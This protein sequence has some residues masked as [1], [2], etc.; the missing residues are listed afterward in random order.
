MPLDGNTIYRDMYFFRSGILK[1]GECLHTCAEK[2]PF[3]ARKAR[4]LQKEGGETFNYHNQKISIARIWKR[5]FMDYYKCFSPSFFALAFNPLSSLQVMRHIA[6]I[7]DK[8]VRFEALLEKT[9][10]K[11]AFCESEVGFDASIFTIVAKKHNV[12]TATMLHG[13]GGYCFP[14]YARSN[15]VVNYFLVPGNHYNKYLKPYCP[16]VDTFFP[17]GNHEVEEIK[18]NP[19]GLKTQKIP[20]ACPRVL[21][22][23]F[24]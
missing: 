24:I 11:L 5:F 18:I 9:D 6:V 17:I 7:I 14:S 3:T 4:Y 10:A 12:K 1:I 8:T 20:F 2:K 21:S 23:S 15:T 16:H 13:L 22:S 19:M